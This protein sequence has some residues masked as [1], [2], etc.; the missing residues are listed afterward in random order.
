MWRPGNLTGG[1]PRYLA[2]IRIVSTAPD[3][4]VG[5]VLEETR[6]GAIQEGDNVSTKL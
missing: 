2:K 1:K 3:S 4:A 6:S 5:E